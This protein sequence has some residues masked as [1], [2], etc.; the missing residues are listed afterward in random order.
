MLKKKVIL[1]GIYLE[2]I[3]PRGDNSVEANL[4]APATLKARAHADWNLQRSMI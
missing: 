4:L 3:Y 1:V 2:G